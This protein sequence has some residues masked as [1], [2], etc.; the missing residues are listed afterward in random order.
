MNNFGYLALL[1]QIDDKIDEYNSEKAKYEKSKLEL[2]KTENV[3]EK[4]DWRSKL[5]H[6]IG[7]KSKE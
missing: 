7:L 6:F 2:Q 4:Q 5:R 1:N 3:E